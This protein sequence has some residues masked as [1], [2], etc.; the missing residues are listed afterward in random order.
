MIILDGTISRW[1][2]PFSWIYFIA[3]T[4]CSII[5]LIVSS[6]NKGLELLNSMT[7]GPPFIRVFST[8]SCWRLFPLAYSSTKYAVPVSLSTKN[9]LAFI[10][11]LC[12][13]LD[14]ISYS[15]LSYPKSTWGFKLHFLQNSK[16]LDP[17]FSQFLQQIFHLLLFHK[18]FLQLHKIPSNIC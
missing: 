17:W 4:S 6:M 12:S 14:K 3:E 9:S 2:T 10:M 18:F 8:I 16:I 1:Q 13:N 7:I 11:F 15:A 5:G